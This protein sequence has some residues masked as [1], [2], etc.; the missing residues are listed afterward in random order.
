MKTIKNIL[1]VVLAVTTSVAVYSQ[2]NMTAKQIQQKSIE[3][4]RV[5][6]TE[7]LSKMTIINQNGQQRVREM[8]VA[9]KLFENGKTE[10]KLIRFTAPADVKG[11]GFLTYDYNVKN[12]LYACI[13]KNPAHY[14]FRKC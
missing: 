8:A 11:V 4:T 12:D 13:K 5:K 9:T 3:A 6:G 14:Q 7:A 10:K 2:N 1:L